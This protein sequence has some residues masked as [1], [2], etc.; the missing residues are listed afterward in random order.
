[1]TVL[2]RSP[3]KR[4]F[5]ASSQADVAEVQEA[6][7]RFDLDPVTLEQTATP[8]TTWEDSLYRCVSGADLVIGVMADR[9]KAAFI[10][11]ELGI[12]SALN[13][14]TLLFITPDYPN[15]LI[16]PWGIP[17]LRMD[18][19]D[20]DALK[21]GLEQ[22]LT[23][24]P[25]DRMRPATPGFTTRPIGPVAD[26]LLTRLAGTRASEFE[27][28]VY[29]AIKASGAPTI[30]RGLEAEDRGVDFAVWSSDLEPTVANPLLI[31]CRADFR[32][33][34][35][36]DAVIGRMFRA[37]EPIHNGCGLV[38]YK[39]AG[40]VSMA[41]PRSLPVVFVP[42]EEFLRGLRDTGLA[43]YVCKLR[44]TAVDGF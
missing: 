15:E 43:E 33:Q 36:V 7:Q 44:K 38:L 42:A 39:E 21:F 41:A 5:I 1:M 3:R 29:E 34:A 25:R 28:L 16:P 35:E 4:V 6:P 12:A 26:E 18:L 40:P 11:F 2:E 20:R 31:E 23:L 17:Y 32:N 13:K 10:W 14:P 9:R 27:D 30:A 24:S 19:R 8:G 22:A 37:L